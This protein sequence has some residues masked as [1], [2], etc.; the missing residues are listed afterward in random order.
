MNIMEQNDSLIK[1]L[2]GKKILV[3]THGGLGNRSDMV[4]AQ[5]K[6]IMISYDD[7]FI[8]LEYEVSKFVEGL[9]ALSKSIILVN[10]AYIITIEEYQ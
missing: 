4:L 5:Y 1:E 10:I 7:K 6:G 2:V 9:N 3:K 8:R